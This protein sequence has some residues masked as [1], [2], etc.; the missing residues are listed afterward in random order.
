MILALL[1]RAAGYGENDLIPDA[2]FASAMDAFPIPPE[3]AKPKSVID[4]F[5][6]AA[7]DGIDI[8]QAEKTDLEKQIATNEATNTDLRQRLA[9]VEFVIA[10]LEPMHERLTLGLGFVEHG[11]ACRRGKRSKPVLAAAE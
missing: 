9:E 3:P 11:E 6:F 2:E 8:C 1:K 4:Q 7:E 10:Q 5:A